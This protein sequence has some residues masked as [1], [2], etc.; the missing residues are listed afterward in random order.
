M[1]NR[2]DLDS[3]NNLEDFAYALGILKANSG[4]TIKQ[5]AQT[6]YRSRSTVSGYFSGRSLPPSDMLRAILE[7]CGVREVEEIRR[8]Q[9]TL[10]RVR[11]QRQREQQRESPAAPHRSISDT[12]NL[13]LRIYIPSERLYAEEANRLLSLFREWLTTIRGRSI[14]QSGYRTGSGEM[15][16]FFAGGSVPRADLREEF[17]NFSGFLA[18]SIRDPA[19]AADLL[20]STGFDRVPAADLAARFGRDVRRLQIDLRHERERR[21]LTIRHSLEEELTDNGINL[22]D[23]ATSQISAV[24]ESLVPGSSAPESLALLAAPWTQPPA[25]VTVNINPQIISAMESTIIQNV[26]GIVKFGP[27]VKEI[28]ALIDRI[29]NQDAAILQSAVYELE[30]AAAPPEA[31]LAAKRRLR[32][33][34]GQLAGTARDVGIDLLGKYL[35]SKAGL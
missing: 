25:E 12:T 10:L 13:L 14:R 1:S 18:L 27:E 8:W 16:E 32:Q 30:D 31:R 33:F 17:S 19:A 21:M 22:P 15:Y 26:R 2:T 7:A 5:I 11:K 6:S 9:E 20:V 35:E 29:G 34:L 4:R 23:M 3:I 24:L 28:L